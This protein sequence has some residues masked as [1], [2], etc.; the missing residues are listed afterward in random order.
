MTSSSGNFFRVTGPLCGEFPAQRPVTRS[1]D[2]FFH[3]RLNKRLSKQWW[4][5]W[6][7]TPSRSLWR[8][9]NGSAPFSAGHHQTQY[10]PCNTGMHVS[11]MR[12][13]LNYLWNFG[14]TKLFIG[15][16]RS[17]ISTNMP[18]ERDEQCLFP[19]YS[20]Y[21]INWRYNGTTLAFC[22]LWTLNIAV[23]FDILYSSQ[24]PYIHVCCAWDIN[25]PPNEFLPM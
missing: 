4:G 15:R 11:S 10:T 24:K 21:F 14:A 9:R 22:A 5:W 12:R 25:M 8:H 17:S 2:V 7:E 13:D 20:R 19:W 3:L 6:F 23:T 18:H 1:F 16:I